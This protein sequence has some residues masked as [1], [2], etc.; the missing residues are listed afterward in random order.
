MI[1]FL[2]STKRELVNEAVQTR[3]MLK[4]VPVDK[5]DWRPHKKLRH[6]DP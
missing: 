6:L 4:I 3:R 2:E 5:L 1:S